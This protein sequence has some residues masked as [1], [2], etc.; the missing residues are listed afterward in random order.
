ME[1]SFFNNILIGVIANFIFFAL[2]LLIGWSIYLVARRRRLLKFFGCTKIKKI[3]IYLSNIHV[4]PGGSIG[5]D[6]LPRRY[7]GTT[8]TFGET[9]QASL[10]QSLFNY[11]IPSLANQPG[12]LK[13]LLVSDVQI[14]IF[15][16][17]LN[18][19]DIDKNS[20]I[21]TFGSP[22]YNIVSSW[23]EQNLNL[24]IKFTNDNS[25]I[26]VEGLAPITNVRQSFLQKYYDDQNKRLVFY[27]AGLSELGTIGSVYYLITHWRELSIKYK[28]NNLSIV[29]NINERNYQD[30]S[31]ILNK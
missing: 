29:L 17:P 27:A 15:P 1:C 2:T 24:P 13:Y 10:F 14:N 23:A 5:P 12:I 18:I 22:G 28:Q 30:A 21:I 25:E 8:V 11:L 4:A 3:V 19:D 9:F 26:N 20:T 16:S 31:I 7:S 6:N